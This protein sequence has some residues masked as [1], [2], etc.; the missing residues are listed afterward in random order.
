M[1]GRELTAQQLLAELKKDREVFPAFC[2]LTV[3]GGEPLL[4]ARQLAKI[5]PS[6]KQE[7]YHIA[8][9]TAADVPWEQFESVLPYTDL[10]LFDLKA[11]SD[12]VHRTYTGVGNRRILDNYA[13]LAGTGVP[14]YIRIPL[15]HTVNDTEENITLLREFLKQFPPAEELE[16]LHYHSFGRAKAEGLGWN[17]TLFEAPA[18]FEQIRDALVGCAKRIII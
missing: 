4:Q 1:I 3:S 12:V 14:I 10:V 8:I 6:V 18:Q 5:L 13:R 2:G 9:D 15:V 17:Q 16:L 7:G 11:M